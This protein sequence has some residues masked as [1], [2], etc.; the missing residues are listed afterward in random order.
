MNRWVELAV[1]CRVPEL[2]GK[3]YRG[4]AE[5]RSTGGDGGTEPKIKTGGTDNEAAEKTEQNWKVELVNKQLEAQ[6]H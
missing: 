4:A 6:R 3:R 2:K 5:G 1:A